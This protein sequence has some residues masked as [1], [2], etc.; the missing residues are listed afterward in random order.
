MFPVTGNV[1]VTAG[2]NAAIANVAVQ[3]WFVA[4]KGRVVGNRRF[5][6]FPLKL[7]F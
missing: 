3:R 5:L 1:T 6:T 7:M 4:K 2:R